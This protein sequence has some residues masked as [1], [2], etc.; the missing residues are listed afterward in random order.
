MATKAKQV[1][2][3]QPNAKTTARIFSVQR[4]ED[5]TIAI[6]IT[7]PWKEVEDARE[8][9]TESL[10]KQVAVPGFRPGKAPTKIAKEK[11]SKEKV[12][13]ELLRK[14]LSDSYNEAVKKNNLTPIITPYIHVEVFEEGTNLEFTAETCEAPV[15]DLKNYKAEVQKL[16]AGSKIVVPGKEEKKVPMEEIMTAV[17]K[18]TETKVPKPLIEAETNRLLSQLLEELKTLGLTLEQFLSS[19]DRKPEDLR[20]EY[21]ERAQRDLKLE[22]VLRKIADEEKITVEEKDI[23]EVLNSLKDEKQRQ[24]VSQNPYFLASIIRQQKTLDF[25]AKL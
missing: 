23:S 12:Q 25:L 1:T 13:E 9:V 21:E 16:T 5:G 22:F 6:K 17:I 24:E 11:L 20:A 4:H 14:V 3:A 10:A 15:V 7:V 8:G 18:N 2:E 19:R